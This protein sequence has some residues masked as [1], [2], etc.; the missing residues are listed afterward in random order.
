MGGCHGQSDP[1]KVL[2]CMAAL[3]G[4]AGIHEEAEA[5]VCVTTLG[6]CWLE[7]GAGGGDGEKRTDWGMDF[8]GRV[9]AASLDE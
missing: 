3:T 4:E 7:P 5:L 8:G 6:R 1:G 2:C 9:R